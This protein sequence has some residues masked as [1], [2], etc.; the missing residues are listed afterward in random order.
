MG[1]VINIAT[2]NKITLN[3]L[4]NTFCEIKQVEFSAEYKEPRQ[5]DIKE[6]YANVNKAAALLNWNSTIELNE[7]LR[8]LVDA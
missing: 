6:S 8:S 7:G 1:Q 5:G 3:Q 4:L 2:G